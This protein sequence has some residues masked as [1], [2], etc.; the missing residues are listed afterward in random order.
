MRYFFGL[1]L[2]TGGIKAVLFDEF[3][4]EIASDVKEYPLYQPYNGWSEQDPE[5]WFNYSVVAIKNVM[6]KSGV[7]KED[8]LGI[9]FSGQ[10]MGLTLLDKNCKPL[11]RAILWNDQRTGEATEA[12]AKKIGADRF[13]A[14]TC[15]PPREGLTAAKLY[16]V[17]MNEPEVFAQVEHILLPKDYLRFRLTGDFAAEMSD[18][19]ATQFLDTPK[20]C[21]S[22]EMMDGLNIK[23]SMLGKLYES[24]EVTG[25]LLPEVAEAVG[26]LPGTVVV[27]GAGDNAAASVGT[28]VVAEGRAF[29]TVGTSGV[30]FAYTDKPTMDPTGGV[31]T[32]CTAVPNAWHMMGLV[33]SAGFSVKWW[34]N[35]FL[36]DDEDYLEIDK[37]VDSSPI[38]ANKLIY[39]PY[40]MGEAS[41]YWDVNARGGFFGLSS[42]HT[43]ADMTRAVMEGVTYGLNDSMKKYRDFGVDIK[44]MRMCGGGSKAPI[45]RQ[46]M[47]DIYGIPVQ[48]PA[49]SSEN[50]AALGAAI[51]AMVGA[52]VYK[53]VP[54][55][56][57]KLVKLR[58]EM[59]MPVPENVQEY[60]KY[61]GVYRKIYSAIKPINDELATL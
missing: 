2:G 54:E 8:V 51:L 41:P 30:V 39:L 47:A 6:E 16:W 57:D 1:D 34:R 58:D 38:G 17:E 55:A 46:M 53:T 14:V 45:W 60:A 29:T 18:A 50:A 42:I 24:C 13:L 28:G 9:G 36:P 61:N 43:K 4:K 7:A 40:L 48:I 21:W 22:E 37:L 15:N 19:S 11:R 20:R 49:G 23:P 12:M 10:M 44:T 33:N 27:G 52:G 26:L 3:G 35:T 59:V 25:T 31:Y 56:C 32:F 5:D